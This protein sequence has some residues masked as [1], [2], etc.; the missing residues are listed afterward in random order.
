MSVIWLRRWSRDV[1]VLLILDALY[2]LV[3]IVADVVSIGEISRLMQAGVKRLPSA[4]IQ[5]NVRLPAFVQLVPVAL[6]VIWCIWQHRVHKA[7]RSSTSSEMRF[8][9]GWAVGWWFVPFANLV[10]PFRVMREA[11]STG[12]EPPAVSR[13]LLGWWWACLVGPIGV[14]LP[15]LIGALADATYAPD[16]RLIVSL[17]WARQT[18]FVEIASI[19]IAIGGTVLAFIIVG[20]VTERTQRT[21][22]AF[23]PVR[24]D[25]A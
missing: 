9:P 22:D 24:P 5:A 12:K 2:L 20:A 17:S 7:L 13:R 3:V 1:R 11:S 15:T 6:V 25:L 10:Q 18:R 21:V 23:V 14:S 8:T 16:G 4:D 19:L